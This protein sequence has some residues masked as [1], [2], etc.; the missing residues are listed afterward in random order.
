MNIYKLWGW[1]VTDIKH[2]REGDQ[3]GQ[4]EYN[5]KKTG[6]QSKTGSNANNNNLTETEAE[7]DE[8]Q[9]QKTPISTNQTQILTFTS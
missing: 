6:F 5:N 7:E 3:K 1:R 8:T 2:Q 9:D 4:A